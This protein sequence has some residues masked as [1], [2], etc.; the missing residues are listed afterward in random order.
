MEFIVPRG[1]IMALDGPLLHADL[2]H[3]ILG[4][5]YKVHAGLGPGLLESVY[6][7]CLVHELRL[8]SLHAEIEVPMHIEYGGTRLDAGFR[9]DLLVEGKVLLELKAV[10]RLMPIHD[11]QLLT[12]IRLAKLQV[13]LLLNFNVV[14][15]KNGVRRLVSQSTAMRQRVPGQTP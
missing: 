11:A 5:A 7:A 13:G 9:A 15:M 4:C 6:R 1:E 8:A 10:E 12:Y 3:R 14:S 2:T